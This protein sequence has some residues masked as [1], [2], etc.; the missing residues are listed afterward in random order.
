MMFLKRLVLITLWSLILP[1]CSGENEKSQKEPAPGPEPQAVSRLGQPLISARP[2]VKLMER[3]QAYKLAYDADPENIENVIWYGRFIAYIGDYRRAIDFYTKAIN[4]FPQDPRLYRHRG[5]RYITTRKFDLAIKDFRQAAKLI[6]GTENQIEPDGMPNARNIPVSTLHGNIW[7]HLGLAHYLSHD[8]E[9][10]LAAYKK[11]LATGN[12]PDNIVSSTHWLYMILHRLD[13]KAEA[14][15]YLIPINKDM[16]VI[17]NKDYHHICLCY[18]GELKFEE[19]VKESE[20][21]PASDAVMYAWGNWHFYNGV[22]EQARE[23]FRKILARKSWASFGY[24]AAEAQY[25]KEFAIR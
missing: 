18:K 25:A 11:C 21:G 14:E 19:L 16:D 22:P 10:A 5:H 13:R 9:N 15:K 7:Y 8:L 1:S 20:A 3:Y 2:S 6:E 23:I 17:E 24:I 4:K 12:N